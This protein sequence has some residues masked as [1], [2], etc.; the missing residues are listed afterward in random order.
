MAAQTDKQKKK[1]TENKNKVTHR[2]R[3]LNTRKVNETEL[4]L[5]TSSPNGTTC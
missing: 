4:H 3:Q 5:T 2:N 1:C